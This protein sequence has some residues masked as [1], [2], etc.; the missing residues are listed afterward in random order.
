M[1]KGYLV[2][3]DIGTG[4]TKSVVM[5]LDGK[6]LGTHYVEYPLI[7]S[8]PGWAEHHPDT[9]WNAVAQ[10][11][12]KSL[13]ASKISPSDVLGVGLSAMSPACILVD[14]ELNP[15]QL[16][17]FWMDRRGT[18]ECGQIA[19]IL[20]EDAVFERSGNPIDSYYATVKLLWEKNNRPELYDKAYKMLTAKDYPL[21][22]LT[23]KCVTDYSNASLIGI[24]FDIVNKRWD[25][26]MLKEIGLSADKLPD[27]YPCDEVVG[28]VT[29][30]AAALTGLMEGTPVVAGTVDCNAA[31]V[32]TGVLNN[33]DNSITLGTAGVWGAIH[34]KPTFAKN[35]ITIVHAADSKT[36]YSTVGALVCAGALIRYFRDTFGQVEVDAANRL[37]ISPYDIMNLEAEKVPP[38]SDGMLVLPYFMGERTPMWDPLAR[39]VIFGAS[40]YH[41]RGHY[42]RSFME[43]VAYGIKQNVD[44][45][46]R[47]GTQ[48]NPLVTMVEGGANSRLWRQIMADVLGVPTQHVKNSLGA[49]VGDAIVAGV[50]V[51]AFGSY[52]IVNDWIS[53]SEQHKPDLNNS[54]LYDRMYGLFAGLY[55]KL[56]DD[57]AQLAEITGFK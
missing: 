52:D 34:D 37:N 42:I 11:I 27:A 32:S 57:F 40:L 43:G 54:Q 38:G 14:R 17:H 46:K 16:S 39:G 56:K 21:M 31:W 7:A 6:V 49:P 45:A 1:A 12:K 25:E 47:S 44:I 19:R 15:L 26:Q 9:Y 30:D 28:H 24:A 8:R 10:T 4:G 18:A 53:V 23:G 51:G 50:G 2:G 13:E 55:P 33:G 36:K 41:T 20:G 5:D 22:K 35:M 3:C 48:V 29:R